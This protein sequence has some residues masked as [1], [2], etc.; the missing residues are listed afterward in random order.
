MLR[1]LGR[2]QCIMQDDEIRQ[3]GY[4]IVRLA[5]L[6][7]NVRHSSFRTYD[8]IFKLLQ[9]KTLTDSETNAV[10]RFVDSFPHEYVAML[11][12]KDNFLQGVTGDLLEYRET[13]DNEDETLDELIERNASGRGYRIPKRKIGF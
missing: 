1:V 2:M 8:R 12:S 6:E 11:E 4:S 10:M 7:V 3:G 9:K 13:F 5:P